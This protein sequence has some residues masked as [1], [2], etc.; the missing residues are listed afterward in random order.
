[1]ESQAPGKSAPQPFRFGSGGWR[2]ILGEDL[3]FEQL[4]EILRAVARWVAER[5]PGAR[6]VV[7]HDTRFQSARMAEIAVGVLL[8]HGLDPW[9]APRPLPTPVAAH[10]VRRL[11]AAAGL[12]LTASHNPPEYHGL[13]VLGPAG[14]S[15][16]GADCR[17]I[18]QLALEPGARLA[19]PRELPRRS[20][21]ELGAAYASE[22]LSLLDASA[23]RE[24][25]VRIWYDAMHGTGAGVLPAVLRRAGAEPRLLRA[26]ADPRFGGGAPDPVPARLRA[27]ARLLRRQ[28]GLCL[29][30]ATD[31][32][33]DRFALVDAQAGVLSESDS[34]ALIVDHLARRGELAGGVAL[35]A[36]TGSLPERVA[37]AYGL[38]VQRLGIG[39]KRL[40]AALA[41]GREELAGDESGGLAWRRLGC[42]KDGMLG[43][44]LAVELVAIARASLSARL[45]ELRRR[46]GRC[47]WGRTAILARPLQRERLAKLQIDPP[48]RLEGHRLRDFDCADG[49]R[50]GFEDGFL[51]LRASGTE[52]VLRLYAEAASAAGL[53]SR[54]RAGIQ[55]LRN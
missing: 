33:A 48:A 40:S 4:R 11:R 16:E 39:F 1:M 20:P 52:P 12:V 26:A 7:A 5:R 21:S 49:A 30:I 27:L 35:S 15:I 13:K 10:A 24:S 32:D 47:D 18:E 36:A 8:A 17:A 6:V 25:R 31:G 53:H 14:A 41:A 22:L 42:E 45:R 29:G 34:L 46:H 2:G 54:L 37:R 3:S 43:A 9:F 51:W 23:L 28:P 44:A 38:R 19:H 50:L 55:L